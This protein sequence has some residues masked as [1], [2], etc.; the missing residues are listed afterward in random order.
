VCVGHL[1]VRSRTWQYQ[2]CVTR[3][4]SATGVCEALLGDFVDLLYRIVRNIL[5]GAC[6]STVLYR[7]LRSVLGGAC[8]LLYTCTGL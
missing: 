7:T 2:G 3:P 6:R 4:C 5:G 1:R 8:R